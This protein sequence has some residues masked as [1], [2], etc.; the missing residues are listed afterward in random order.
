MNNTTTPDRQS[1]NPIVIFGLL[2][3]GSFIAASVLFIALEG[4]VENIVANNRLNNVISCLSIIGCFLGVKKFRDDRLEGIISYGK[5][6]SAGCKIILLAALIYSLYTFALYTTLPGLLEAYLDIMNTMLEKIYG[7]TAFHAL[8]VEAMKE[9]L[10]P[11]LVAFGEFFREVI[12][13]MFFLLVV[14]AIL[15]RT[16]PRG[17]HNS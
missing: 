9:S 7:G 2:V 11:T 3:G 12:H 5:A 8:T 6:F 13:W 15:R 4:E 16:A 10:S 14:A 1:P 17:I